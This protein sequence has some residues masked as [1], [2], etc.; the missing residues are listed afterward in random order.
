[1][2]MWDKKK[3]MESIM[4]RKNIDGSEAS[5]PAPMKPEISKNEDGEID[6]RHVAAQ[7]MISAFHEKSPERLKEAMANFIDI[8]QARGEESEE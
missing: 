4:G 6:G 8:H 3:T 2:M 7:D 1:M 5:A